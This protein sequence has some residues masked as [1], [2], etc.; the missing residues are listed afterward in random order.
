MIACLERLY[1]SVNP[2]F[3]RDLRIIL[4]LLQR[5]S[6]RKVLVQSLQLK[7]PSS[8]WQSAQY[9]CNSHSL[10][11]VDVQIF[12]HLPDI[13]LTRS[14]IDKIVQYQYTVAR[15]NNVSNCKTLGS[16]M[17]AS[18]SLSHSFSHVWSNVLNHS[19]KKNINELMNSLSGL[20]HEQINN[21]FLIRI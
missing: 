15:D 8:N 18:S 21:S 13:S 3:C 17:P 10:I 12:L 4:S 1:F 16:C 19:L 20:T 7:L 14:S 5:L 11:M 6:F 2:D 9:P